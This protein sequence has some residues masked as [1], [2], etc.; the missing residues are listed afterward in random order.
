MKKIILLLLISISS[1]GQNKDSLLKVINIYKLKDTL[2]CE[3][4]NQFIELE[5]DE[6]VWMK[7][8]AILGQISSQKINTS[9]SE[10]ERKTYYNYWGMHF[11]NIGYYHMSYKENYDSALYF[12]IKAVSKLKNGNNLNALA[13]TLQNIGTC[14]DYKAQPK[15]ILIYYNQVLDIYSKI[16]D[17]VGL[18]NI[19]ADFGRVYGD[20]G[21]DNKAM[22]FYTKSM[23]ISDLIHNNESKIRALNFLITTL[24]N[25]KEYQKI[26]DYIFE[27]IEYYKKIG[28]K[29]H[30]S[31]MY[32]NVAFV[33]NELGN[34]KKMFE[35]SDKAM[36]IAKQENS[37]NRIA[38]EHGLLASYYL[39]H[40]QLDSAYKY[41]NFEQEYFKKNIL[42][43][44]YTK[45]LIK[46]SNILKLKKRYQEA[47]IFSL[48]AFQRAK[49]S[50]NPDLIMTASRNLKEIYKDLNNTSLAFLDFGEK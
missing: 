47:K 39:D 31:A 23:K 3:R 9:I 10:K 18:A 7:Y 5:N 15:Q 6:K 50:G 48:N 19:Y 36:T 28:Q 25:Q 42:E 8:N 16:K 26:L 44:A 12:Y 38:I 2:Q 43:P 33:Y 34:Y 4:L 49:S 27:L 20:N 24:N 45:S 32:H 35:Y 14:Y 37:T 41:G 17:S 11:N 30:L 1:S 13:Q 46:F 29:N 40:N 21:S 22:E